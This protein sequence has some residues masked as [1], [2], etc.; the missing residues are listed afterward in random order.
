[1]LG[2]ISAMLG[3]NLGKVVPYSSLFWKRYPEKTAKKVH[4]ILTRK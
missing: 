4:K 3:I 1:M 2:K